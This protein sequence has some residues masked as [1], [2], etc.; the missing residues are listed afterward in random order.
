MRFAFSEE[1]RLFQEA[2]AGMLAE[3]CPPEAV[4]EAWNGDSGRIPGLW[5]KLAEMGVVGLS[6]PEA[7]GGLGLDELDWVLLL[8]EAGRAALPEPLLETSAVAAPL[9]SELGG[10]LADEWLPR[11]A[12]GEAVVALGLD[13]APWVADAHEADLFLLQAGDEI[14]A[15]S[16]QEVRATAQPSV[17]GARRL[18]RVEWEPSERT[19]AAAGEGGRELLALTLDR[20]ALG[21][22]AQLVGLARAMLDRSV[23]YAKKREQ[24][25]QAIGAFQAVKHQLSDA[26]LQI[27]FA[28]PLVAHAAYTLVHD[29]DSR[30]RDVST[31]KARASDAAL[32]CA[33]TALQCHGAIGYSFEYPLHLWMKRSWSLA[34]AHGDAA[35]HRSRL[36]KLL[37]D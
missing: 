13:P 10:E 8:Q 33:K 6:V 7:H 37:L 18:F 25:G 2:L 28:R 1:Q 34:A 16:P 17:D 11:I 15:L 22:A 26:L 23:D 12:A 32:Q 24:F 20:A 35:W 36:A 31:A 21:A 30:A 5:A 29:W 14:H 9:L 19:R 4:A 27:E 3:E